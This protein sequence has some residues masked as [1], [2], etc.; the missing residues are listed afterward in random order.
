MTDYYNNVKS[1]TLESRGGLR[2]NQ[3]YVITTLSY[4]QQESM[5][6]MQNNIKSTKMF[7]ASREKA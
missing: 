5:Y 2:A 6:L 7:L 3:H 4:R 1:V